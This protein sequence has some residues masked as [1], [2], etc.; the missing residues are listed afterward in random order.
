MEKIEDER[1][2]G[3]SQIGYCIYCGQG[4]Q[5][6]VEEETEQEKLDRWATE[7]CTCDKARQQ[8]DWETTKNQSETYIESLFEEDHPYVVPVMKD[9]IKKCFDGLFDSITIKMGTTQAKMKRKE[10][11]KGTKIEINRVDTNK[12]TR[13][14]DR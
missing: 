3:M 13:V 12:A 9:C 8:Q 10:T 6:P 4:V 2:T 1:E 7:R 14:A 5:L 11:D